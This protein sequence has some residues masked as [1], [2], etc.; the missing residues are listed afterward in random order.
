[1][2]DGAVLCDA[3]DE[4]YDPVC[5]ASF[6]AK[7]RFHDSGGGGLLGGMIG[8]G[9]SVSHTI[10]PEGWPEGWSKVHDRYFCPKHRAQAAV[11]LKKAL[12]RVEKHSGSITPKEEDG[13]LT[14]ICTY[15][16]E[17]A[18]VPRFVVEEM[19]EMEDV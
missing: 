9:S 11:E 8:G 2:V 16:G 14:Y 10:F 6:P 18:F 17:I 1:M 5:N 3:R 7:F 4:K 13:M 15:L 12:T 19:E